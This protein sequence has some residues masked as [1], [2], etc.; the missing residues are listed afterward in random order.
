M[1]IPLIGAPLPPAA[2][3]LKTRDLFDFDVASCDA[4]PDT[5]LYTTPSGHVGTFSRGA[6]LASVADFEGSSY[7]ALNAQPAL[8]SR[9]WDGDSVREAIVWRMGTADRLAFPGAMR[10]PSG[11]GLWFML[12]MFETGARTTSGA[13]LL[14]YMNDAASGAGFWV[15]ASA[16]GFYQLNYTDG[17]TVRTATI[18]SGQPA[19]NDR[20]RFFGEIT[21]AGVASF[22]QSINLAAPTSASAAALTLPASWAAS[23]SW[24]LNSRGTSANPAQGAYRRVRAGWGALNQAAA[25]E[26]R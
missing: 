4:D 25:T 6:T 16:G 26:R 12:E 9:D 22:Y 7:T 20:V 3:Y 14:A 8:E 15:D 24:R 13:T 1:T 10:V 23:A 21:S 18:S 11:V 5:G 19:V 2:L 17:T